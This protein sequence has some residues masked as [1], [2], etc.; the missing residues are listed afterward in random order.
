MDGF[1]WHIAYQDGS[2]ASGLVGTDMVVISD[3]ITGAQAFGVAD[4]VSASF[5]KAAGDGLLGL[6]FG[7]INTTHQRTFLDNVESLLEEPLFTV[8]L[9]PN[10]N[11]SYGFGTVDHN[12]YIGDIWWTEIDMS[13]GFWEFDSSAYKIG[14][15]TFLAPGRAGIVDTGSSLIF[16]HDEAV[17]TYY[18]QISSAFYSEARLAYIFNCDDDL[19]SLSFQIGPGFY[20]NIPPSLMIFSQI[21]SEDYLVHSLPDAPLG[22]NAQMHS[23]WV[24]HYLRP[25]YKNNSVPRYV[26]VDAESDGHLFFWHFQA[27][28]LEDQHRTIVWLNGGPGCSSMAGAL[29]EVGPY[30]LKNGLPLEHNDASWSEVANV[31]FVDSP[32]GTG[33][34]YAATDRYLTDLPE[35]AAQ[36]LTFLVNFLREFPEYQNNDA[37]H[38]N[39]PQIYGTGLTLKIYLAGESFARQYIPY[40]AREI[41][42]WNQNA[43]HDEIAIQLRGAMIGNGWISPADQYVSYL[44]FALQKGLV[45]EDGEIH[46]YLKTQQ[47]ECSAALNAP[48]GKNRVYLEECSMLRDVLRLSQKKGL[49]GR[50]ECVNMYNIKL[51]DDYPSCGSNWPPQLPDLESYLQRVGVLKALHIPSTRKS[52]FVECD[53]DVMSHFEGLNSLSSVNLLPDLLSAIPVVLFSGDQDLICNFLGTEALIDNMFWNGGQG[54]RGK[55][56]KV[57][58][59]HDWILDDDIVGTFQQARSVTYVKLFNGSH[60]VPLDHGRLAL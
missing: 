23:G 52:K 44:P 16:M 36:F 15:T 13:N 5:L 35:L 59:I 7:S 41:L 26:E 11:G 10:T 56:N 1:S 22:N 32:I 24:V 46:Q 20:A 57:A 25:T 51:R 9:P 31:L 19:P 54:F 58:P 50:M 18:L 55:N 49:S 37:S 14:S 17:N 6:A 12:K 48:G 39:E 2:S 45:R 4:E 21:D 38:S 53:A 33:F 60:M 3:I 40:I 29:L 30:T 47:K 27:R 28:Q 8:Y 34:S 43:K 42:D